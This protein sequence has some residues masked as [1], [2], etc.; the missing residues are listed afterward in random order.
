MTGLRE[1]FENHPVVVTLG[2]CAMAIAG[3][4]GVGSQLLDSRVELAR[5]E[6]QAGIAAVET[7]REALKRQLDARL[8]PD[9]V[10]AILDENER[11]RRLTGFEAD[12]TPDGR[13]D[14][15]AIYTAYVDDALED[16]RIAEFFDDRVYAV[17]ADDMRP[18][19][20]FPGA[21]NRILTDPDFDIADAA[22]A[23]GEDFELLWLL[24]APRAVT[25]DPVFVRL[26]P[27]V[28]VART[29]PGATSAAAN[30]FAGGD[31]ALAVFVDGFLGKL[32]TAR[33]LEMT[34]KLLR[35]Q[36]FERVYFA[37]FRTRLRRVE[38]EGRR[39]RRLFLH[40]WLYVAPSDD[41]VVVVKTAFVSPEPSEAASPD[42]SRVM[43]WWQAL[44]IKAD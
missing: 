2:A 19:R 28:S 29:D 9:T 11:L 22:A 36:Q 40:E 21:T 26:A 30:A 38:V 12:E 13:V 32:E 39:R 24:D 4:V 10:A 41:Q 34:L 42:W 7:E 5:N 3:T 16:P 35:M 17:S 15:R 1:R 43:D 27:Y 6:M 23:D 44:R 8:P 33:Q 37:Q 25:G 18:S 20:L 31:A 14:P